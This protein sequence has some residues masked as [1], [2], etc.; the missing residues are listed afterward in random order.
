MILRLSG[1][2]LLLGLVP[3]GVAASAE[4]AHRDFPY[5]VH[6]LTPRQAAAQL[7]DRFTYGPTPGQVDRVVEQGL[8]AWFS[9]QLAGSFQDPG[10]LVSRLDRLN[11]L[12]LSMDRILETYP[13]Q[14]RVQREAIAAG[15]LDPE[16]DEASRR[17]ALGDY[18]EAKGYR[19]QRELLGHAVAAKVFRAALAPGQV[20]EVLV[21][22]WFNHLYVSATDN[23]N[24]RFVGVYER[25]VIRPH[26]L[27]SYARLLTASAKHPAM[28]L[29][30]DNA[31]SSA[32]EGEATTSSLARKRLAATPGQD[33]EHYRRA[34]QRMDEQRGRNASG[35]ESG[36]PEEFRPRR[37]LNENYARELLELH[38]LG[39][40]GGYTQDD[41]EQVAR[42]LTG[43][44][45]LPD[46]ARRE[47]VRERIRENRRMAQDLGFELQG[48]FFFN[49]DWHDAGEKTVLGRRV[50]PG[51]GLREGELI[52]EMLAVHPS[53]AR[54]LAAKLARRFVSD[55]PPASLVDH[56]TEVF[57]ATGG[58]LTALLW[59]LVESPEFW[60]PAYRGAKIKTPFELAISAVRATGATLGNPRG[61]V[62]WIDRMGQPL[63]RYQAPTGFPDGADV[64]VNAG[65]LL[66]RM[67]FGLAL[68]RGEIRGVRMDPEGLLHGREPESLDAALTTCLE[69]MVPE[70]SYA[71]T[72][73][74]VRPLLG[75]ED[76]AA[77]LEQRVGE[78]D[79][80]PPDDLLIPDDEVIDDPDATL[81]TLAH[82]VGLILGSPE[83]QRR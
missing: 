60:D 43:W 12:D 6:G 52:L 66:H 9:E 74:A 35:M 55:V 62:Q 39:V 67:N 54:H 56:L 41:V 57:L 28:L 1:L 58:D 71:A 33:G 29:Y 2:V 8:E 20:Q 17:A 18:M 16:L 38:T 22:F 34:F 78:A 83:F 21:D 23:Q 3:T 31:Q 5:A 68:A 61:L 76:L 77:T 45:V 10:E 50:A 7:L 65:S 11:T 19:S 26:V 64:W 13:R 75:R 51:G 63:Y 36:L 37:G 79:P 48:D 24:R 47:R 30:L 72:V 4:A 53:T 32:P 73:S 44:T 80:N 42:V 15:K 59:A 27:G 70:R 25:D 69:V 14:G 81:S 46:G 40:D 49:A 82:V